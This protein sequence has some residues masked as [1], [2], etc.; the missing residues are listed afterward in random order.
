MIRSTLLGVLALFWALAPAGAQEPPQTP[1]LR[2]EAG[3]HTGAVPRLAVDASGHL[4][5]SAGYDKTIRLWSLPDGREKSVLRPPIG[6][7]EEGEIYAVA[8][9]PDGHRVFAGGAT[10]GA[11]SSTFCIYIFDADKGV[12]VSLLPGLPAPVSDL[13]VSPDGSRFAAALMQGGIRVWDA[14]SGKALFDDR[15]IDGPVRAILFDRQNRLFATSSDG[16]VRAYGADGKKS[17]ELQPEPGL[18]PWGLALSPDG[19]LLGVAYEN[20]DKQGHL[21]VDVLNAQSLKPVF[22]PDT[23]GLQGA[24]LL[25]LAW[26]ADDRGSVQ[27]MAGGYARTSAGNV[28]RRWGDFGLGPASDLPAAHDTILHI[29][30]VPGGGA[31]YSTEDPGW[32]RIGAD[33]KVALKPDPPLADLRPARSGRFAVSTNGETVEFSTGKGI[34]RFDAATRQLTAITNTDANLAATR[35]TAP[36]LAPSGW[37]DSNAPRLGSAAVALDKAEFARSLTILPGDERVLIGTDTHLRLVARD[38]KPIASVAVP[39]AAWAVT[40]SSDGHLAIAALLDGTIRWYGLTADAPLSERAALFTHGDGARW[41]L[42]TPEGLFDHADRGGAELIGVHLNRAHNQQPEWVSF[43]Q[44]YRTLYAPAAVRARLSGDAEPSRAR[45]AELGDIRARLARQPT[46]E[47]ASACV[48]VADG[49]CAPVPFGPQRQAVLPAG[50]DKLRLHLKLGDRGLGVGA[51]DAFV[52]ERNAGRFPAPTL[53]DKAGT[54]DIDVPIDPGHDNI[55]IRAYDG[56]N[57]IFAETPTIDFAGAEEASGDQRGTLYVL[58][59]GIDHY[60]LPNLALH[61]AVADA[62]TFA[63]SIKQSAAPLYK[64]VDV[65]LLTDKDATKAGILAAFERLG[66]KVRSRDTF[67]FYVASHGVA[68]DDDHR[69]LLVPQDVSDISSMKALAAGAIDEST[70][71]TA[72]S[73]IQAHDALLLLDTC[74]SGTVTADNLAN[75]GHE[76]GRYILAASSSVQEALDSYDNR[77]GVF[78][79]ALKEALSGRAG[80]DGDGDIGALALGEYVSKRVGQLARERGHAQDA[81]FK[82]AQ[83]ELRS[84]PIGKVLH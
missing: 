68:S 21:H 58:A 71:I 61:F 56:G 47:V 34:L 7:K 30:A 49:S 44:A 14:A 80:Q 51:I 24:G 19:G 39:A 13:A 53:A 81:E 9:T 31:V 59:I 62:K 67:L 26:V 45:L 28:L 48:P 11:W 2:I 82:A 73:R 79:Y 33:G 64:S 46:V 18:R 35:P 63:D 16:K 23:T 12:L 66:H 74:H 54:A 78:V 15:M 75:V 40:T 37:Q 22:A 8:L 29:L 1:F 6:A 3:G 32:G 77:N 84:F 4:M 36:G 65:T 69:F 25:A 38:G 42:F 20:A 52:N 70:L 55:Q 72:L 17:A 57:S 41:T 76:S 5:A 10:G 43:S 27:L 83:S 60:A 50:A